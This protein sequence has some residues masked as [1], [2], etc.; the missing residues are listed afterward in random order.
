MKI[1]RRIKPVRYAD[2]ELKVRTMRQMV[3]AAVHL[4][5]TGEMSIEEY[6]EVLRRV[7]RNLI[8]MEARYGLDSV[9]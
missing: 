2:D 6:Q 3:E 5:K 1:M 4:L 7:H 8:I 9:A